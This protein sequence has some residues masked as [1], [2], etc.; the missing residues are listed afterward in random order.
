MA[1]V[2][3]AVLA[4]WLGGAAWAV[5]TG[6]TLRKR[7]E[8]S[9]SQADRLATLLDSTPALPLMVKNDGRIEAPARLADW[10]GLSKVPNFLTDLTAP[11][12][13]LTAEDVAALA[14]DV[15]AA[16]KTGRSFSRALQAQGSSRTLLIKGAPAA[17]KL[18]QSGSVLLWWFDA[19]E[20]QAEI[21]RLGEEATRLKLA[22]T[23]L[24][25]LI[26]AAPIPMWYRGP[27]LSMVLVNNAFV[28]AVE[29]ESAEQ[30]IERNLEL[31]DAGAGSG[32]LSSAHEAQSSGLPVSRLAP[33][34]VAGER[35]SFRIVDV[36]LGDVGIAGYALD[37]EEVDRANAAFKRFAETQ[38][39]MLDR[40]SSGVAQFG[41]DRALVFCNQP[42]RSLFAIKPEWIAERPD[43]DRILD[44]MRE[45]GR[46]P[47]TRDFPAWKA[48]RRDW[49]RAS[50]EPIEENWLA[51]DGRHLRLLAQPIPDGG[52][53]LIFEDRTEQVQ[54][55]SARDTLLRV[56][57]A[58]FDSLFEAVGVFEGNGKLQNWNTRFQQNWSL[59]EEF[60]AGHPHID[61]FV[62]AITPALADIKRAGTIRD[63]VKSATLERQQRSGRISLASG[64]F[65]E[66]ASVPLPDGNALLTMLDITDSRNI[67]SALRER[68]DALEQADR[69][70]SNFV[71]NMSYEL[72][73]P[74][75]SIAGYAEMLD[76]GLAGELGTQAK[77]YVSSILQASGRLGSMIDR[78]LDLT[79]GDS[80]ALPLEQKNVELAMLAHDAAREHKPQALAKGIEFVTHVEPMVGAIRGDV[81]R[82]R[83]VLDHLID[84]AI[85]Y[86]PK[87]GRVLLHADGDAQQAMIVVSD[88]GPGMDAA[89]QARAFDQFSR[90]DGLRDGSTALG[91]GLPVARHFVE[92]HGGTLTLHSQLGEGTVASVQLPR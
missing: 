6:L 69:V 58:T 27:D 41:P 12:A 20:S 34:T 18:A 71:S 56:R 89:S 19:T 61:A 63:L 39:D 64:R 62:E 52:L 29:A 50:G 25:A 85:A 36:P 80:G 48:E 32:P 7:A 40:L 11:G 35:R 86:T 76:A 49:F 1:A 77:D 57:T 3:G 24:S 68:A 22:F 9:A 73:T 78:V 10:L 91:L 5:W 30:V 45:G 90:V 14:K 46:I 8:F 70:K 13:G 16:Q 17:V 53:V 15:S 33:V 81:R 21:G 2:L 23:R 67:E 47:E 54:L 42:F 28:Q 79:Q 37:V 66:L 31:I 65:F 38:R 51:A 26:E 60:L 72:R 84:N 75:T 92:A 74:L 88:N 59:E 44:R 4:L 43:F 83:Q 87:G 82:L 55:A